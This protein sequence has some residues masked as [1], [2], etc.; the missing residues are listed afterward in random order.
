LELADFL[1]SVDIVD[2]SG[3]IAACRH[4]LAILAETDTT[5]H[6]FVQKIV[7]KLDIQNSG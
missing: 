7:K 6:T 5:H 1:A 3:S 4:V 2:L